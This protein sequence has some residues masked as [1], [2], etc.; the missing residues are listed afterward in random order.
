[1]RV[2]GSTGRLVFA[3]IDGGEDLL[4]GIKR[5]AKEE[6][7]RSGFLSCIG[8]LRRA[9]VGYYIGSGQYKAIELEGPLEIACCL[10]NI[11]LFEGEPL[12]HAHICVCDGEG[13]AFGGHL[14]E[15]CFVSPTAELTIIE[16]SGAELV[17]YLDERTGLKLLGKP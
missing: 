13:R 7:I 17:R 11:A 10:G 9:R 15:G 4:L 8:A 12:V 2:A 6:N 5:V 1:M 3:R 14:L 16:L